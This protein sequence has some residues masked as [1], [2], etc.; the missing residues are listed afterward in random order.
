MDVYMKHSFTKLCTA[1]A[2][3][4]A[5]CLTTD[6]YAQT[7]AADTATAVTSE[8]IT[9]TETTVEEGSVDDT[10]SQLVSGVNT[11][12]MLLAAMLVFFMQPGFA[13]VEA[14]FT[15]T[16]NT[17]NIL[18]KNFVDFIFGSLLYWFV[19]FGIMFGLGDFFGTPHF[20]SLLFDSNGLPDPASLPT[21]G[22][23]V[24]QTVFCAT[25]ATIVSG[26]MAERTRFSMYLVY[27]IF[28]S[29]L[30]YPVS[31]HWTWGGGWLMNSEAGSFMMKTFGTTFHDFA[32]STIVHSVGG[33]IA[34]VGAAI[35]GPRIGKYGKDGQ[36]KAIPGHNLTIAAL[37]VFILW[38][39]WFGFNPGSQLAAATTADQ[40]A[41]SLVFLNTN[42]AACAGG[43][44]A[45]SIS[46]LKYGKPSLSLTLNGI[47]AGLV[48]ITAGCDTV[49]PWGAV[50]IG[51]ICG[52]LMIYSVEFIDKVLK[53]DDPVGASS[54][55]GVCGLTGT[56]LTGLF[57][58]SEGLFY[59]AG[60]NFL[61]A[62]IFGAVLIGLWAI[63]M[64]FIIFK[65]L[66]KIH[67]LRVPSRI[68]EEGLDIYEH[69]ESAYN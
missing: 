11:V 69:G 24:F 30:I 65:A 18:M 35:L 51:A 28:I 33:W 64:G 66:D 1:L 34:L 61:G 36:S 44:F 14:G 13:L 63:G 10:V 42:L 23:L 22:F 8:V 39:G 47:L 26:A 57:S 48:G 2:I 3:L 43:F 56:I 5:C 15:R 16:K 31:G 62:Q 27:T 37:G 12:W 21:E 50:V 59:G 58:T 52:I 67:G 6:I 53:I 46:W 54:V 32:G 25:S 49:S 4:I 20:M 55:H 29:V 17:A 9:A 45:L 7:A 19:G 68:E 41:I 38:F 40:V 60:A